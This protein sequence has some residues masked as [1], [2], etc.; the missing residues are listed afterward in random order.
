MNACVQTLKENRAKYFLILILL[1][2]VAF[3]A[4]KQEAVTDAGKR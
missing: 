4:K 3:K 1:L 2:R